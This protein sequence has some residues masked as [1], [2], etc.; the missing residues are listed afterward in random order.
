MKFLLLL[1]ISFPVFACLNPIDVTNA[2]QII[3]SGL[4]PE[5]SCKTSDCVCADKI[6]WNYAKIVETTKTKDDITKPQY[7][8][9]NVVSCLDQI[10][11]DAKFIELSCESE[12]DK[13]KNYDLLQVYCSKITSYNQITYIEK[14]LKEDD[15]KKAAFQAAKD[16]SDGLSR[17]DIIDLKALI[18]DIRDPVDVNAA[19]NLNQLKAAVLDK[20]KKTGRVLKFLM[21][22]LKGN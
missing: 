2:Q 15:V 14:E 3:A 12:N 16:V 13:I 22:E 21:K 17:Q 11:C 5:I 4:G 6:N 18:E 9:T 7:S 10:D 19:T 20:H 8:K 1:I